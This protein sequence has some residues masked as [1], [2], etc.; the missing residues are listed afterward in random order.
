M[1]LIILG[2]KY[3]WGDFFSD[4]AKPVIELDIPEKLK[5]INVKNNQD[6]S[7]NTYS[8]EI[9]K[10][11]KSESLV[12]GMNK[13]QVEKACSYLL[14]KTSKDDLL[15][16]LAIANCVVSNFQDSYQ[17]ASNNKSSETIKKKTYIGCSRN[18]NPLQQYSTMEKQLL[19]GICVSDSI[20]Q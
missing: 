13:E 2:I 20:S 15:L 1:L 3:H 19:I 16:E 8:P 6:Q 18:I 9:I 7:E 12:S 4:N 17:E 10:G 5:T 14:I 11:S